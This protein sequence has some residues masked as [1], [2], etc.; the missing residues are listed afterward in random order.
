LIGKSQGRPRHRL[1]DNI[2]I[3]LQEIGCEGVNQIAEAQDK[4]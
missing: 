3:D 1:V 4:V 2:I